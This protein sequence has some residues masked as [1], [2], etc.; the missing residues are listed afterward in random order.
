M[1]GHPYQHICSIR[2]GAASSL[3]ELEFASHQAHEAQP[4]GRVPAG[5]QYSTLTA[6]LQELQVVFLNRFV[7]E[8]TNYI[9]LLLALQKASLQ[10][11]TAESPHAL[12]GSSPRHADASQRQLQQ[13]QQQ[14]KQQ[15]S[16][17]KGPPFVLQMDVKLAA[18]VITMPRSTDSSDSM[19]VDLGSL[20]LTNNVR[21]VRGS[22]ENLPEVSLSVPMH[23]HDRPSLSIQK[24]ACLHCNKPAWL[25]MRS[26]MHRCD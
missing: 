17:P 14:Q 20:H 23:E 18:P 3:I 21:F 6:Q 9:M 19:Q 24:T 5:M 26:P 22:Q 16:K 12:A 11:P 8:V 25:F 2:K 4:G 1:Q 13:Q 7:K 10:Q 15:A